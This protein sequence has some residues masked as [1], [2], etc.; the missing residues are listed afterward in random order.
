[1]G[2]GSAILSESPEPLL[3][4]QLPDAHCFAWTDLGKRARQISKT[5]VVSHLQL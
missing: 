5:Q 3:H 2:S 4:G 1:M